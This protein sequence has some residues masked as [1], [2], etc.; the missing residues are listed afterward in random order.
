MPAKNIKQR[1][2]IL[3]IITAMTSGCAT[4]EIK[5]HEFC[6]DMGSMGADC[7]KT[8]TD[9]TRH[10]SKDE[11]DMERMGMI[12]ESPEVFGDWKAAILKLCHR[13]KAC[14][15]QAEETLQKFFNN[16]EAVNVKADFNNR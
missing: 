13:S 15:Y 1:L 8:L 6:G 9:G 10:L 12:C 14:R 2:K 4:V 16:V 11:W 7:F 5:D 3:F